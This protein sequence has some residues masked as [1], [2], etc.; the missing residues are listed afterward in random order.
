MFKMYYI[1]VILAIALFF[2]T[3]D[4]QLCGE[5]NCN[6]KSVCKNQLHTMLVPVAVLNKHS[7]ETYSETP[8]K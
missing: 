6:V 5:N 8:A 4:L 1:T 7:I 2:Y 3:L